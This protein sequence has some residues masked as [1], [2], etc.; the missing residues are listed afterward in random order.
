MARH[1]AL[2]RL[3]HTR[4]SI[5]SL[6]LLVTVP[7]A[8]SLASETVLVTS[9]EG[10]TGSAPTGWATWGKTASLSWSTSVG[11]TGSRSLT[12]SNSR[13]E[14]GWSGPTF[15]ADGSYASNYP[16][17]ELSGWVR[18]D[19]VTGNTYLTIAWFGPAGWVCNADSQY[20]PISTN[21]GWVRLSVAALP[22]VGATRG[23]VFL[24]SDKNDGIVWFDDIL[25]TREDIPCSET[26][27]AAE[28]PGGAEISPYLILI[29]EQP[30]RP[31]SAQAQLG[32]ATRYMHNGKDLEARTEF[33]ALCSR[34]TNSELVPEARLAIAVIAC[35]QNETEGEQ[36][37]R[38]VAQDYPASPQ[39]PA[40]LTALAYLHAKQEKPKSAVQSDFLDA[41]TKYPNASSAMECRYRAARLDVRDPPDY[42]A[43]FRHLSEIKD[44][45]LD[46]RL[47]A[48]ALTDHGIGYIEKAGKDADSLDIQKGL[49]MLASVR[50]QFPEQSNSIAR[51]ELE[52]ARYHM[53]KEKKPGE[54]RPILQKLLDDFP[55]NALPAVKYQL[56]YCSFME[57]KYEDCASKCLLVIEDK[58]QDPGWR[59]FLSLIRASCYY[60][61]RDL[62]T[63]KKE[64]QKIVDEF[65]GSDF[66]KIAADSIKA[67]GQ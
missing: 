41:A 27:P 58:D 34:L 39:A 6:L 48:E 31:A 37:L 13:W 40:A 47:A 11:R 62:E 59:G 20:A 36:L 38:S 54:A 14:V 67:M 2:I 7:T 29:K 15:E 64:Y 22:P 52:I 46:K 1:L 65:P 35:K 49:D 56:A 43:G 23:Q 42:E 3:V 60:Q 17:Y 63:A 61:M 30:S 12:I 57:K 18:S 26:K 45:S 4:A 21:G 28:S 44:S 5:L 32:L 8:T 19:F 55:N 51:A 9:F 16:C 66:A 33:E 25:L 10:Q 50:T 53:Y 24:R